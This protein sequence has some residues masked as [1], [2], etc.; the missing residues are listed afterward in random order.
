MTRR[1]GSGIDGGGAQS[2]HRRQTSI[3]MKQSAANRRCPS[4]GRLG[5]LRKPPV[6]PDGFLLV[7]CRYCGFERGRYVF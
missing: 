1:G 7:Q 5:A 2:F 6:G 3:G 4:C